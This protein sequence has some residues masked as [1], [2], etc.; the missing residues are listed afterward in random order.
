MLEKRQQSPHKHVHPMYPF[1]P[2]FTK[3]A[4]SAAIEAK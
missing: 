1:E 3:A 2:P 4:P